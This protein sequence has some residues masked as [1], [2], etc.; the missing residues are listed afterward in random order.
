MAFPS[1]YSGIAELPQDLPYDLRQIYA[2]DI[3]GNHLKD[4]AQARKKDHFPNYFECLK[5]LFIVTRHKF[6]D[7]KFPDPEKKDK[8]AEVYGEELFY[9]YYK[10]CAKLANDNPSEWLGNSSDS[11]KIAEIKSALNDTEM[12]LYEAMEK[13]GVFGSTG[14]IP[15]L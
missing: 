2:N 15:G 10:V 9:R 5:D 6:K 13:G 1:S 12:F 7:K 14:K 3:V 4:L 11:K 8:K